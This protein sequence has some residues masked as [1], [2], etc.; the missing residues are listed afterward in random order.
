MCYE[1]VMSIDSE[2]DL[3]LFNEEGLVFSKDISESEFLSFLKYPYRWYVGSYSGCSCGFRH[4]TNPDLGFGP[5]ESWC[6]EEPEDIHG[7]LAFLRVVR[8]L[9]GTGHQVDCVSYWY[10]ANASLGRQLDVDLGVLSEDAFRFF[11]NYHFSFTGY[12]PGDVLC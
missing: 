8:Q 4:L 3:A 2:I 6:P 12:H 10:N 1:V 11:E 5:P 7:T 9:L